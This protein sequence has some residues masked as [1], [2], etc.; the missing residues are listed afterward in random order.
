VIY[1]RSGRYPEFVEHFHNFPHWGSFRARADFPHR[2][3]PH[4]GSFR[5]DLN[6]DCLS[7][8]VR[9]GISPVSI[10][11]PIVVGSLWSKKQEP[12]E[13]NQSGKNNTKLIKSRAGH[14]II[15]DDKEGAEKIVIVDQT[16]K[17]KI[18]LDSV[19]KI[20]KIGA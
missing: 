2:D 6:H 9:S 8:A 4:R 14:R 10:R 17:N 13:V 20:V 3:F 15:F 5:E 7:A 18:I 16:K 12:V 19:N 11:T 1:D